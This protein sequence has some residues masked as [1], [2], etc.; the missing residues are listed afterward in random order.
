MLRN[1]GRFVLFTS[2]PEQ[3]K[4]YWLNHYF[5]KMLQASITQMPSLK[6][7]REAIRQTELDITDLEKYPV[8]EDLQDCFLYIGKNNPN[9]YFDEA[10]RQG[11][12]SFASLANKEEV[13]QGLSKLKNDI[14]NQT[15]EKIKKQYE[16]DLG[17]YL[18]ITIEKKA[19]HNA[20]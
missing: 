13:K 20:R 19:A 18:F 12:S 16:N 7:I 5:P 4:G 2:T 17:D 6:D 9:R 1:N 3:M 14:D 15:F 8:K 10:I 11:I